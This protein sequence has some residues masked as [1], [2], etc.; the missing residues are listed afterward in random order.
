LDAVAAVTGAPAVEVA[1]AAVVVEAV[2]E[3]PLG[4]QQKA[5]VVAAVAQEGAIHHHHQED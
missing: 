5:M 3:A 4:Q 1:V 2:A